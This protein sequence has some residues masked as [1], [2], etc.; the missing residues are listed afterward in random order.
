M[1]PVSIYP[2]H[3][4][5]ALDISNLII[6]SVSKFI[7][8]EFTA[9]GRKLMLSSMT[10]DSIRKNLQ[11]GFTYFLAK[12]SRDRKLIGVVGMKSP[13]Y[14]FHLF[15]EESSHNK[16]IATQ[17]WQEA[18]VWSDATEISVNASRYAL[19]FYQKLGFI[20]VD[21]MKD[22]NGVIYFPMKYFRS[23]VV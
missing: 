5:D 9:Q 8:N 20:K 1:K 2:A 23:Q 7:T 6:E 4:S 3:E 12:D 14:L 17:L 19:K 21:E 10:E 15:I 13:D 18:L 11:Q 16:G 22:V